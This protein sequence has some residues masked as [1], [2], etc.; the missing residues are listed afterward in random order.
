ML[1]FYTYGVSG[2]GAMALET[3][4]FPQKFAATTAEPAGAAGGDAQ[5]ALILDPGDGAIL[6][7]LFWEQTNSQMWQ[8]R[9]FDLSAYAGQTIRLHFGTFNDGSGG[10]TGLIVDNVSL[11]VDADISWSYAVY[12]PVA[13]KP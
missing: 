9:T 3:A 11:L 13:V 12:L 7:T 5:Y 1:S 4:V 8:S 10:H 6:E 2:S